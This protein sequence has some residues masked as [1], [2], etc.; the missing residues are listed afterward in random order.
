M[1]KLYK[2]VL[3]SPDSLTLLYTAGAL[4][5]M[6]CVIYSSDSWTIVQS[7]CQWLDWTGWSITDYNWCLHF[8]EKNA[9]ILDKGIKKKSELQTPYDKWCSIVSVPKSLGLFSRDSK[10]VLH[11]LFE[12]VW[13]F[14]TGTWDQLLGCFLDSITAPSSL[15]LSCSP[16]RRRTAALNKTRPLATVLS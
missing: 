15:S 12:V 16:S 9:I 3:T 4:S 5:P 2:R 14:L 10:Y 1:V 6:N 13:K 7:P 11:H 8:P